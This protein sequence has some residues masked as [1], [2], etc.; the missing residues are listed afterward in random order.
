[1]Q[2]QQ[3]IPPDLVFPSPPWSSHTSSSMI[4]SN[5]YFCRSSRIIDAY[6][7]TGPSPSSARTTQQTSLHT[8]K[9]LQLFVT[10]RSAPY[11]ISMD[12]SEHLPLTVANLSTDIQ[13]LSS[14]TA[15]S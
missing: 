5:Q 14:F 1:M 8:C 4:F 2:Q 12:R 13:S 10:S 15:T 9:C 3:G 11:G 7:M 6:C